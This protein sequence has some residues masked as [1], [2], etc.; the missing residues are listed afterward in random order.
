MKRNSYKDRVLQRKVMDHLRS[1]YRNGV[2]VVYYG[3]LGETLHVPVS[4]L[5]GML[6]PIGGGSDGIQLS[7]ELFHGARRPGP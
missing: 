2:R 4:K 6:M 7:G 5:R 1:E 3:P